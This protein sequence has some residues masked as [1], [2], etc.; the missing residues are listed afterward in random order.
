MNKNNKLLI[1][2]LTFVVVCVVGYALF[3]ENI[4][5]TGSAYKIV[6]SDSARLEIEIAT[7]E[8]NKALSYSLF[9]PLGID[10]WEVSFLMA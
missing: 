8:I 3:S 9:C 2:M 4:T 6:K 5:V 1:G 10:L 7:K